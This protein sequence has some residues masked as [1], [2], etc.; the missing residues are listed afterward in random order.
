LR[1]G[2]EQQGGALETNVAT[3]GLVEGESLWYFN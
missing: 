3:L 2:S 1:R